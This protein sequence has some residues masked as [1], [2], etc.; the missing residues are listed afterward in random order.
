M[1]YTSKYRLYIFCLAHHADIL[2]VCPLLCPRLPE[3][4]IL[5]T[6]THCCTVLL[7][8]YFQEERRRIVEASLLMDNAKFCR[9]VFGGSLVMTILAVFLIDGADYSTFV[10]FIPQFA[11]AAWL[12]CVVSCVICCIRGEPQE[13]EEEEVEGSAGW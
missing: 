3:Y 6:L 13:V 4:L 11:S 7:A 1:I 2:P 5:R 8:P 10:V 12:I 9:S